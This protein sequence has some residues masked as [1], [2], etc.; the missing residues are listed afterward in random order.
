MTAVQRDRLEWTWGLGHGRLDEHLKGF[1]E[2][3]S[4]FTSQAH[5][6]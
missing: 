5:P 6:Y 3:I 1:G 4:M 2:L